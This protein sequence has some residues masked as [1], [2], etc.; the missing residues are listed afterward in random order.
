MGSKK[1][2]LLLFSCQNPSLRISTIGH[3]PLFSSILFSF[4]LSM[5]LSPCQI[6]FLFTFPYHSPSMVKVKALL[7]VSL[8]LIIA[9]GV[10]SFEEKKVFNLQILQRKQ[11]L[12]SLGC[13]HPESSEFN[14]ERKVHTLCFSE[15]LYV[16]F[17]FWIS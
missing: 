17:Y 6:H 7:L 14:M 9:N 3:S 10:S 4:S 13:L 15:I 16:I 11:Q 8:C 5:F 1:P 12:G 2:A